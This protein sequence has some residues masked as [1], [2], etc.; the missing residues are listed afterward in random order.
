MKE[1]GVWKIKTLH[2]F[3][4][5]VAD[6]ERGWAGGPRPAPGASTV[7]PPDKPPTLKYQSYPIYYLQPFHYPNPV[8]GLMPKMVDV[9]SGRPREITF[10]AKK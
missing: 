9:Q 8:T 10:D 2:Q 6:L 4:T 7:L 1:N 5:F 3:T